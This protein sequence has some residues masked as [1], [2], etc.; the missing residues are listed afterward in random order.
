MTEVM[1]SSGV[2]LVGQICSFGTVYGAL[3]PV[4]ECAVIQCSS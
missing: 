3:F 1:T 4:C 2:R